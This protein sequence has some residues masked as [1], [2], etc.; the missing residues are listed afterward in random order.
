MNNNTVAT[1]AT[2]TARK[3]IADILGTV[4]V[5]AGYGLGFTGE[6][7]RQL[8]ADGLHGSYAKGHEKAIEHASYVGTQ[9]KEFVTI[10]D[11]P[12]SPA[13]APRKK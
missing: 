1:N 13:P 2:T 9:I 4:G 5:I 10:D 6:V 3:D 12:A 8:G 11:S 7:A